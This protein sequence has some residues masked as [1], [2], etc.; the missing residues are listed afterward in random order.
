MLDFPNDT[1]F[2]KYSVAVAKTISNDHVSAP[3]KFALS[4]GLVP[5]NIDMAVQLHNVRLGTGVELFH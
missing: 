3:G 4:G 5:H 2:F 1:C